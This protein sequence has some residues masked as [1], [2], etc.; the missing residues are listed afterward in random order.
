MTTTP[1]IDVLCQTLVQ[2][3]SSGDVAE[4]LSA[5]FQLGW[6]NAM[7]QQAEARRRGGKASAARRQAEAA[8]RNAAWQ[9]MAE[10]YWRANS[11][12]SVNRVAELIAAV[13]QKDRTGLLADP[14]TI[15]RSII[16]PANLPE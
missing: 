6:T 9:E 2:A 8:E 16:K 11:S 14:D 3:T 15:R 4:A 12:L 13:L 10:R 7:V 5:A 1:E